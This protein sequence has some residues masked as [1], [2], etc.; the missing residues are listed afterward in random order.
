MQKLILVFTAGVF[1]LSSIPAMA[2]QKFVVDPLTGIQDQTKQTTDRYYFGMDVSL[3][4]DHQ[5]T[6]LLIRSVT[7]GSPAAR[8]GLEAG[9]EIRSV[10]GRNFNITRNTAHAISILRQAVISSTQVRPGAMDQQGVFVADITGKSP[11]PTATMVVRNVR[12]G[13]NVGV[14]VYPGVIPLQKQ[15]QPVIPVTKV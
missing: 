9:D 12:N 2:Q 8:A 13:Q 10:N 5:G 6:T 3:K 11:V 15:V 1:A 7:P 4:K 14:T